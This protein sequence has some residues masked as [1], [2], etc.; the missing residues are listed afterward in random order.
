MAL[1]KD[2]KCLYLR[3]VVTL[4]SRMIHLGYFRKFLFTYNFQILKY[5]FIK[6]SIVFYC[7]KFDDV[8]GDKQ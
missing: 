2:K 6:Y 5:E 7:L 3:F 8:I 4:T 1:V